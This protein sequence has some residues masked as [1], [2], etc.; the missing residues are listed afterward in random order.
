[1]DD[2]SRMRILWVKIG[3][4]WPHNTGGR[5]RSFNM[6]EQL[7]CRQ[8]VTVLTT[9]GPGESEEA[10]RSRL[11]NCEQVISIPHTPAK[12]NSVRF[13][14]ALARA[15]L[16][17]QPVDMVRSLVPGVHDAA[18][19][20]LDSGAFDVC[21]ADFLCA[22]P[23]VPME[24]PTPVV[25][26]EHNAEYVIWE[27]LAAVE[28][29]WWHRAL[30][31]R[32]AREMRRY[33]AEA[34]GRAG[35]TVAVSPVDKTVLSRI[36]PGADIREI[37]TGVDIE[38]FARAAVPEIPDHLVFTGS[39]DWR[40]NED[41]IMHFIDAILPAIRR[42]V[43]QVSL[44]VVGRNPSKRL[45]Q[46]ARR[47]DVGVTGTVDDIRPYVVKAAVYVVPLRIGGGTRLK[48]CEALSMGKAVVSTTV[49]A[50]GLPLVPG[51]HFVVA[52]DPERF[53]D[54]VVVL[55][56]DERRRRELGAAGRRLM[57]ERHAWSRVA[58]EFSTQC[59]EA[60]V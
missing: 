38:Y 43:P 48:I 57:E 24:G 21:I 37:P 3:G 52:D 32:E 15:Y 9:H 2:V 19:K 51:T 25:L 22:V 17:G 35:I 29:R 53:A 6:I 59:Q 18:H 40:P 7:S 47:A 41:A 34:C 42:K 28:Q 4:L 10:L 56:R 54:E 26:F 11:P 23:N 14:G 46:A 12:W 30:L 49:G 16:S 31:Q 27:R 8:R 58:D 33:E 13:I 50:E 45:M 60:M 55:L 36:A 5:L 39:M 20:L 1:M 44:T